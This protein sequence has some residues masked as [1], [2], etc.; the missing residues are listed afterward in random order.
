[1]EQELSKLWDE[2]NQLCDTG[3]SKPTK[4]AFTRIKTKVNDT[5]QHLSG[6]IF[7]IDSKLSTVTGF[8]ASRVAAKRIL[9]DPNSQLFDE[10]TVALV[11]PASELPKRISLHLK[12]KPLGHITPKK[13]L[14][15]RKAKEL[16]ALSPQS[17]KSVKGIHDLPI[18]SPGKKVFSPPGYLRFIKQIRSPT[19]RRTA[20]RNVIERKLVGV[21]DQSSPPKTATKRS[22]QWE[23][24]CTMEMEQKRSE[25]D[26][27][28][29]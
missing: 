7:T 8:S 20:R 3:I 9:D 17:R 25:A 18:P 26:D 14:P 15:K 2:I 10:R 22:Y 16:A 1:M 13:T 5:A 28:H 19:K 11:S 6:R 4:I 29:I 12:A 23:F 27:V 24:C 21:V